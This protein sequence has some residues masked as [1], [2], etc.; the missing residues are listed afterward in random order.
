MNPFL[1][2]IH[3]TI[4]KHHMLQARE[5]VLVGVSG[6]ADST[7]LALVLKELGYD[8]AIAHL[9]HNLRG[10]E[11]DE[12]QRFVANFAEE[13]SVPFFVENV[14]VLNQGGNLEAAGRA[15][16]NTFFNAIG[17]EHNFQKIAIGHNRDDRVETFMLHLMRGAGTDGLTSMAPVNGGVVR[18]LIKESREEILAFLT[19]RGRSWRADSTNA[20]I[21]FA[22]N[23]MR[24]EILPRLSSLFNARL[25]EAI[26]RTLTL[27]QDE[28]LWMDQLAETWLA[29][30]KTE[31]GLDV[32]ALLNAPPALVRRVLRSYMRQTGSKLT[33]ITF[34]HVEAVRKLLEGNKSGKTIPLPGGL[35]AAREF[36]R[37]VLLDGNSIAT[38]FEYELPIPGIVQV[39]EIGKAFRA[40]CL[41]VSDAAILGPQR[42]SRVFVDGSRIGACV[43]IR[44]WKPGDYYKPAGWPAGKVKKLFQRARVPRSQRCRW[45]V[46]AT[47]ATIVWVASFPVSREFIPGGCCQKIVAFETLED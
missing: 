25:P 43:S 39:P 1:K 4:E 37:L 12:D 16:R 29:A 24:L 36:D 30:N 46:F 5:R 13:L 20:D 40:E 11:S 45:P 35:T 7:A 26:S 18:P 15:A 2:R 32:E 10:T 41:E 19:S 3:E 21:S 14:A 34:E 33:D 6:G 17:R 28:E 22:R 44:N 38:E 27:L 42:S 31:N 8:L 47:D 23:R 9:N